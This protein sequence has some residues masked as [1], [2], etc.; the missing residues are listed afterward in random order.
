MPHSRWAAGGFSKNPFVVQA[1]RFHRGAIV[2][3]TST[4]K[5]PFCRYDQALSSLLAATS[6]SGPWRRGRAFFPLV[7][8]LLAALGRESVNGPTRLDSSIYYDDAPAYAQRPYSM[9]KY[10]IV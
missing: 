4:R 10:R 9:R 1:C 2:G 6:E 3:S 5:K 8:A 7:M